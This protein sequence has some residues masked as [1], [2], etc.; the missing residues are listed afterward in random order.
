MCVCVCQGKTTVISALLVLMLADG[1]STVFLAVPPALLAQSRDI[2]RARFSSPALQRRV[3]TLVF[4]R[5]C[6]EAREVEA[7]QG[8][9][10][11]MKDARS[12]RGVVVTTV[13]T[14]SLT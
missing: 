11:R 7:L 12:R 8:L 4:D 13:S 9:S 6:A 3:Y 14:G 5:A 10:R 1:V 2:M